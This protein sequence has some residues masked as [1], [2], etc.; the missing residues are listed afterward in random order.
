MRTPLHICTLSLLVSDPSQSSQAKDHNLQ[1]GFFPSEG[2]GW[3]ICYTNVIKFIDRLVH[4]EIGY[5]MRTLLCF[6][7]LFK[8][9]LDFTRVRLAGSFKDGILFC[10]LLHYILHNLDEDFYNIIKDSMVRVHSNS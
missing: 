8:F 5:Y 10:V 3:V 4:F 7:V 2:M 6:N 1:L 9:L